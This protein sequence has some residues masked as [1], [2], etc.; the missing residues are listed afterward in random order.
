MEGI[1][2][3]ERGRVDMISLNTLGHTNL[4]AVPWGTTVPGFEI[5]PATHYLTTSLLL[6]ITNN[7][8]HV[9]IIVQSAVEDPGRFK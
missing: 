6:M 9:H 1:L 8:K 5:R 2:A 4:S 7:A 3:V